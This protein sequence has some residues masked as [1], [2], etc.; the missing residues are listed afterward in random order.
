[1]EIWAKEPIF[2][3][4]EFLLII[5]YFVETSFSLKNLL[6][7]Y[8][9]TFLMTLEIYKFEYVF[10]KLKYKL[11]H[12]LMTIKAN[13]QCRDFANNNDVNIMGNRKSIRMAKH[14]PAKL[15][16]DIMISK[17]IFKISVPLQW[18]TIINYEFEIISFFLIFQLENERL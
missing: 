8:I 16:K 15:S 14:L 11:V 12:N 9:L 5:Y 17:T 4:S 6:K 1:M 13:N 2:P 10:S 3:T 18:Q 7:I